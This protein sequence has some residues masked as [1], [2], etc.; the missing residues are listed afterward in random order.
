MRH[1][2]DYEE[3]AAPLDNDNRVLEEDK[4][5]VHAWPAP[6]AIKADLPPAPAFDAKVLLPGVLAD[7][8]LDEADRM[9][10]APDYIAAALLVSLGSA[11]GA[12]CAL[13]PKSRDDWIITPNLFGAVVGDPSTKKTPAT[14][15]AI[16]FLDRLEAIEADHHDEALKVHA[17]EM[18][19]FEAHQAAVKSAMK[20]AAAGKGDA[21]K[22]TAAVADLSAMVPP[23]EPTRRRFKTSDA[24][25]PMLGAM[26][27]KNPAG[28]LV[29]R[30]ELVGL[31]ATW[32]RE[33]NEGD[34]AFYLEGWNGT[35]SFSVDRI[36]RGSTFIKTLCLS[37]F[38]GIQPDLMARYLAGALEGLSNDGMVQ[39]FQV[40]VFPEPVPWSWSDRYPVKGTREAVRDIFVRLATFDPLQDGA[41]SANEF[42][43]LPHFAFDAQAQQ[44][45][46]EWS[47]N[48]NLVRL[49]AEQQ[50]IMRQHLAKYEKLFGAVAL[51]MH[52]A[53]GAVGPVTADAAVR[54]TAWC[55]F[56][57][58][59]ARRVYALAEVGRVNAAELLG[60]RIREGKL[61]NGFTVRDVQRKDW[62]GL[63]I[64]SQIEAALALLEDHSWVVAMDME[65]G[66][67]RPTTRHYINPALH[68]RPA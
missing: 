28:M 55:E 50:A 10:C 44:V 12:R 68:R 17:A 41:A 35:G 49:P 62:S 66:P 53:G 51:I 34:R 38:G 29:F 5:T 32:D 36:G 18:A 20:R 14:S 9:P 52:L 39:R 4:A 56:L 7:F 25:V 63:A 23:E 3:L 1:P 42:V 21:D 8:V 60:R 13:K 54:A 48:L 43:K 31:L 45:F 15:V 67:G 27:A 22:M 11:I 64:R 26:L 16:R 24:T 61:P 46:I 40:V 59:H 2:S 6:R 57:E 47:T 37:V 33:G 58:G 30:D 19:A 65:D